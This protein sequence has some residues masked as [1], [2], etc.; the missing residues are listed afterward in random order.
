[1]GGV[2]ATR[3]AGNW[4]LAIYDRNSNKAAAVAAATGAVVLT[5][6]VDAAACGMVILAV[7]DR[8]VLSCIEEFNAI[9]QDLVVFNV[10]TNVPQT[11]LESAAANHIRCMSVKIIGHAGEMAL[12]L[13]PVIVVNEQPQPLIKMA[14]QIFSSIGHV[15]VGQADLVAEI[16]TVAAEKALEA[17]VCIEDELYRRGYKQAELIRSA[18]SQV[19]AGILKAYA[20]NDLGPFAKEIVRE[21]QDKMSTNPRR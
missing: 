12:G 20:N 4:R 17:A 10:A 18:I 9:E 15:I 14:T 2:L 11:L 6:L 1:M 5:S 19:A 3:L 8:E 7:P 13:N 21:V 16:N